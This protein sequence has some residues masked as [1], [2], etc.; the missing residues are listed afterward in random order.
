[1]PRRS[2]LLTYARLAQLAPAPSIP[3]NLETAGASFR[4]LVNE[5]FCLNNEHLTV[6]CL[7]GTIAGCVTHVE[8]DSASTNR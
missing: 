3:R 7:R 5:R 8:I 1:M 4:S 2:E 6:S